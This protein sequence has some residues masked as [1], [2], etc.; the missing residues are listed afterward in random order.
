MK[1]IILAAGEGKRL[2]PLTKNIPKCLVKINNEPI[3]EQQIK[4]LGNFDFE[5]FYMVTGYKFEKLEYLNCKKIYNSEYS[6]TNMLY[7]LWC[8]RKHLNDDVI[9]TYGDS[10]YDFEL[11]K[12]IIEC[13]FEIG[14]AS[15][16]NWKSFWKS[17]YQ[18]PLDDL[19]TFKTDSSNRVISIG[20]KPND[21]SE[22]NGQYIGLIKLSKKGSRIFR[23]RLNL[24]KSKGV[25]NSKPFVDA[26]ITD[27][28]Q[29]LI[30][31]NISI[32]SV[33]VESDYIEI[34]TLDDLE[35]LLTKER[36][37]R[38]SQKNDSL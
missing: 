3:I 26:H 19:E 16:K 17:R 37:L 35:S 28:I 23:N 13:K 20:E 25:V 10:V 34:D 1:S 12:T 38:I 14:I 27:F 15:D 30:N 5:D 33:D 9:I 6:K 31:D 24:Y 2:M 18:N 22:V 8:A 29:Q 7:S 11:I 4:V 21:Y 36:F 32:F